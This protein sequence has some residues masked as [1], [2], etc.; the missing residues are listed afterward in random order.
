M[1]QILTATAAALALVLAA[2]QQASAWSKY[3]F[4][5]GLNV[6]WEGG[7]NS[8]LFG[9]LKGAQ[10]PAG[11]ADGNMPGGYGSPGIESAPMMPAPAPAAP[12]KP[13]PE[14]PEKVGPPTPAKQANYE[15]Q[16]TGYYQPQGY[17]QPSYQAYYPYYYPTYPAY[18]S[19]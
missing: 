17:Y 4:G 3:N 14:G 9:V 7:G 10:S 11:Y 15:Y 13:M 19:R 2:Q 8:F 12:G 1:R 16:P 18:W 5:V 6:G